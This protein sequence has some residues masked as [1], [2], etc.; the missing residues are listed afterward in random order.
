MLSARANPGQ[1]EWPHARLPELSVDPAIG[2]VRRAVRMIKFHVLSV[3]HWTLVIDNWKL[4][5][6]VLCLFVSF[7][8][9]SIPPKY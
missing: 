5:I 4:D 1:E 6:F 8:E 3:F 7:V 9:I 2:A